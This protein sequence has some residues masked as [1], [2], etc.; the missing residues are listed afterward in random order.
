[1]WGVSSEQRFGCLDGVIG[2]RWAECGVYKYVERRMSRVLWM[3]WRKTCGWCAE[4]SPMFVLLSALWTAHCKSRCDFPFVSEPRL[5]D[6]KPM[7]VVGHERVSEYLRR[8]WQKN[9]LEMEGGKDIGK[10]I[11]LTHDLP[12]DTENNNRLCFLALSKTFTE[13][14]QKLL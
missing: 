5:S 14:K 12:L 9:P 10:I 2:G 3:V 11:G 8:K 4:G 13:L 7:Q 1:M 6:L